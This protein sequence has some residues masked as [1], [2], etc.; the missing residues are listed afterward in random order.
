LIQS[1]EGPATTV[2]GYP[3]TAPPATSCFGGPNLGVCVHNLA[4]CEGE[5]WELDADLSPLGGVTRRI[6]D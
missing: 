1:S 4:T 5:E 6:K 2:R 3:A